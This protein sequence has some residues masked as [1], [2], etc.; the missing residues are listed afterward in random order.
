M[1]AKIVLP[2]K[3]K[4]EKVRAL[5]VPPLPS[6]Q[7]IEKVFRN[8]IERSTNIQ[9]R[10][11]INALY[12]FLVFSNYARFNGYQNLRPDSLRQL[13]LQYSYANTLVEA[14]RFIEG[15]NLSAQTNTLGATTFLL[16]HSKNSISANL[17]LGGV[18]VSMLSNRVFSRP[19]R[20]HLAA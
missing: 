9:V 14:R 20:I 13:D 3:T 15:R 5:T 18:P 11:I 2:K 6:D 10:A 17:V 1:A 8:G 7:T 12:R 16:M 19:V 4:D